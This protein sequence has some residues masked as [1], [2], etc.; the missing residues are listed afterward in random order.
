MVIKM[1]N[2]DVKKQILDKI[3]EYDKI[4]LVRHIRP[5]GDCVGGTLGF[6]EIIKASFPK[7]KVYVIAEDFA[8][9]L[10]FV[11]TE[12][13][14]QE[15][16]YY[17][18]ALVIA[19]DTATSDRI[20]N[21]YYSSGKE[22]I[23]IDHHIEVDKY[24]DINWVE[25]ERSS[26]CEMLVEFYT[27]FKDELVLNKKAA[28]A[29]YVG[30]V[31]DSGRFKFSSVSGDTLR[32]ASVLVDTGINLER[33]YAELYLKEVELLY[34]ESD[35]IRKLKITENGVAYIYIDKKMREKH[36]LSMADASAMIS[37][38]ENIKGSIIWI[39]FIENDDAS[40]RVR[41]RSRFVTV[42][43]LANRYHG[44]GHDH[45]S[46]ATVYSKKEM[47]SLIEEA[48]ALIKSYK[49]SNDDWI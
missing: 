49:E 32:N 30:I 12:D 15:E 14:I 7:K 10:S 41:L 31:T 20:S 17:K 9:Y 33:I 36:N 8:T 29:L 46:G 43:K 2:Y 18:D 24:G 34:L 40:I 27:T 3:K 48:D 47:N 25:E 37:A 45:A 38:I 4:I 28:T 19:L 21:K 44:G 11:G 1:S 22:L 35:V 42:D 23:K 39:A 16:S 5:D 6:R 26:L 13:E